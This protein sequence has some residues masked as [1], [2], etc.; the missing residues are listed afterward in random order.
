MRVLTQ[1]SHRS[2]GAVLAEVIMFGVIGSLLLTVLPGFCLGYVKLW[3]RDSARLGS[4]QRADFALRRMQEDVRNAR[5]LVVSSDGTSITLTLPKR[6]Y[7]ATLGRMVNDLDAA[8]SLVDGDRVSYFFIQDSGSRGGAIYR[9]V[10][11]PDG[12]QLLHRLVTR[13]IY[14]DLNPRYCSTSPAKPIF[15]YDGTLRKL[16]ISMTAAE[17]KASTST[18]GAPQVDPKCRRCGGD[19]VRVQTYQHPEGET[20]CSQCGSQV[21]PNA[22]ITT[23]E[24]QLSVRNR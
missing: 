23:Y 9:Q 6:S 20:Q 10:T 24:T 19:L 22:E 18:F 3:Q 7:D 17:L 11:R 14:P 8:G 2:R 16:S 13:G 21:R 12:T 5:S 4:V 15:S 1:S